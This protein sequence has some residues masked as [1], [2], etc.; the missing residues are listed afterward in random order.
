MPHPPDGLDISQCDFWL[1][2]LVKRISKGRKH[3]RGDELLN[4]LLAIVKK[5]Q[6]SRFLMF[7]ANGAGDFRQ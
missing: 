2:G 4:S 1:I 5:S 3:T 6:D 7:I